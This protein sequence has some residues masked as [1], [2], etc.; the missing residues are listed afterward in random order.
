MSIDD[1]EKLIA[2]KMEIA[3]P[4]GAKI[5]VDLGDDG[6]LFIDGS[7]S[8]PVLT[9][10]RDAKADTTLICSFDTLKGIAKGSVDPTMAYMTGALKIQGSMGY[11]LKLAS[12]L[13]D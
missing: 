7:T 11:A 1:L 10:D 5:R 3:P 4:L 8:P 9:Q 13:E 2:Q 6:Q 12:Y